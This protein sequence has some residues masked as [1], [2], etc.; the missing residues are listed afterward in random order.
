[1]QNKLDDLINQNKIPPSISVPEKLV[2]SRSK[3][4][5]TAG[6]SFKAF[7]IEK[8]E[9]HS[10]GKKMS[11]ELSNVSS[12]HGCQEFDEIPGMIYN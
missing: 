7:L 4:P 2:E 8:T 10:S 9:Q 12:D 1:L 5:L 6:R 3:S 11:N